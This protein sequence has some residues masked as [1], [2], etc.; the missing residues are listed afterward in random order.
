VG[1]LLGIIRLLDPRIIVIMK[2]MGGNGD[3]EHCQEFKFWDC[4]RL[5]FCGPHLLCIPIHS[6]FIPVTTLL[7]HPGPRTRCR[8]EMVQARALMDALTLTPGAALPRRTAASRLG[9]AASTRRIALR[10][11]CAVK[12]AARQSVQ[13]NASTAGPTP[14]LRSEGALQLD[15]ALPAALA[16]IA[17]LSWYLLRQ[18]KT[19]KQRFPGGAP[20]YESA[21]QDVSFPPF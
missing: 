19:G 17:A 13:Q 12:A 1:Y 21:L 7:T 10:H 18:S 5:K 3:Q 9:M 4:S 11:V 2:R 16:A 15:R 8:H 20:S 14:T 6:I